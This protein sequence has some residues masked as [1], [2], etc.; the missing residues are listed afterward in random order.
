[1]VKLG[2]IAGYVVRFRESHVSTRISYCFS[3]A[4]NCVE[5]FRNKGVTG[6]QS[7]HTE[8]SGRLQKCFSRCL[9]LRS[10]DHCHS[11]TYERQNSSS[12]VCRLYDAT[13]DSEGLHLLPVFGSVYYEFLDNC[14]KFLSGDRFSVKTSLSDWS[15]WS[16]CS[17]TCGRG[18][19]SRERI[20]HNCIRRKKKQV[21]PC[22][23][24]PCEGIIGVLTLP[25]HA[26][27]IWS[28]W[29]SWTSCDEECQG[30]FH[31]LISNRS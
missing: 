8:S 22:S 5:E 21:L 11:L 1:M 18:M 25:A 23:E 10:K 4:Y 15:E 24:H 3:L 9:E 16:D 12:T 17:Q 2:I 28:R 20:C 26:S 6:I 19:K 27:G 7:I 30:S 13:K 29:T 14:S 31:L